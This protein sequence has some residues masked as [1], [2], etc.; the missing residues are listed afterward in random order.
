MGYGVASPGRETNAETSAPNPIWFIC[1]SFSILCPFNIQFPALLSKDSQPF[2][3][4]L[5][6]G[7]YLKWSACW[8][9]PSISCLPCLP[10]EDHSG[11][12]AV[13]IGSCFCRL[14]RFICCI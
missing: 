9:D 13:K 7:A 5:Q 4:D 11:E 2:S 10:W 12:E 1:P 6:S 8:A 14:F 3:W